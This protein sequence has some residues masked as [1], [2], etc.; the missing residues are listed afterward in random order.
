MAASVPPGALATSSAPLSPA[1]QRLYTFKLV[2]LGEM[3]VGKSSLVLQFVKRS[4]D[5]KH[6]TT[7]GAAYLTQTLPVEDGTIKFEIWDTAGQER[8]HSLAP[9]Y[10]R[11][12]HA[13]VI[14]YDVTSMESFNRAKAWVK[15]LQSVQSTANIVIAL[16]GNKCDLRPACPKEMV[17]AY[18]EENDLLF[19]ET[20][21]KT[22]LNVDELFG[23]IASRLPRSAGRP[24]S[25]VLDSGSANKITV[26]APST[27]NGPGGEESKCC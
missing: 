18:A 2:L 12:A 5:P 1:A 10:Y 15:E 8:Y 23:A 27:I 21:A 16:A 6:E 11:G 9:M 25:I 19:M 26:G 4:F 20:S 22:G 3:S 7:I 24:T 13:A 17:T 14:V